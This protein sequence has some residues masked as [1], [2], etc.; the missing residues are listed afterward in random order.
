[1]PRIV[2][3][4]EPTLHTAG[5][6]ASRASA[7]TVSRGLLPAMGKFKQSAAPPPVVLAPT[8]RQ[9]KGVLRTNTEPAL[10]GFTNGLENQIMRAA[11][12][13]GPAEYPAPALPAPKGGRFASSN[14]KSGLEWEIYRSAQ[15]PGPAQYPPPKLQPPGGGRFSTAFP[16]SD[17][18]WQMYRAARQPGP[19]EYGPVP[20]D[21]Y[22]SKVEHAILSVSGPQNDLDGVWN[23]PQSAA[24]PGPGEYPGIDKATKI[25][26]GKFNN[27][28]AKSDL[29]W[30]MYRA[31]HLPGPSDYD[32][33]TT[34]VNGRSSTVTKVGGGK[35]NRAISK[36]GLEWEIYRASQVPGPDYDTN[37]VHQYL[38][39]KRG[40][41][42]KGARILGRAGFNLPAPFNQY[43]RGT[44]S[45]ALSGPSASHESA[46]NGFRQGRALQKQRQ[47]PQ[48]DNKTAEPEP[49]PEPPSSSA[50]ER[51]RQQL[52]TALRV[53]RTLNGVKVHSAADLFK[54]IDKNST[55]GIDKSEL[56]QALAR[57]DI[58]VGVK[59]AES[60]K[61]EAAGED[62]SDQLKSLVETIDTDRGE[63]VSLAELEDWLQ[64]AALEDGSNPEPRRHIKPMVRLIMNEADADQDGYLSRDEFI[65]L[66]EKCGRGDAAQSLT[67][68]SWAHLC[69]AFGASAG[70]GIDVNTLL[71]M[72]SSQAERLSDDFQKL[73][74]RLTQKKMA[75]GNRRT[76]NDAVASRK[77]GYATPRHLRPRPPAALRPQQSASAEFKKVA[78]VRDMQLPTLGASPRSTRK[79]S[80]GTQHDRTMEDLPPRLRL[81]FQV[82]QQQ[83]QSVETAYGSRTPGAAT[84]RLRVPEVPSA[85]ALLSTDELRQL[86]DNRG[87]QTERLKS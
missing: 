47:A 86:E 17:V 40:G 21:A 13:P 3:T 57:L 85:K 44:E 76:Q 79:Q 51:L 74:L 20:T 68:N 22:K 32:T 2:E 52:R 78:S 43:Y 11:V 37:S 50:T 6:R 10:K 67:L 75:G 38:E 54:A 34:D 39:G 24:K 5:K 19:M 45:E 87:A 77:R 80:G 84:E 29:E 65:A 46:V 7:G 12:Q 70:T 14:A 58:A 9:G 59:R 48:N 49:E 30:T 56:L 31:K 8:P 28:R 66:Q 73:G 23:V 63:F 26:G 1:M 64:L 72:Y 4:S 18:E 83:S 33:P 81:A 41:N 82:L 69:E 27:S 16:K 36:S 53:G 25:G 61:P 35:W 60:S 15:I 62:I 42:P 55:G 71:S